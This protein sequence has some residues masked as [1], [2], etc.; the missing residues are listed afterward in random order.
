MNEGISLR[1]VKTVHILDV[2]FNFGRVDQ[3]V[4]RAIRWCSHYD[5]MNKDHPYPEVKLY[6]YAV[7]LENNQLST[8]ENLYHKAELKYLLKISILSI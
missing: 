1:N 8:E 4:A 2:Y 7:T 6:K 3:V 5:L